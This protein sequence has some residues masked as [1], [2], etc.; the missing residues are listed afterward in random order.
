MK[1]NSYLLLIL[2]VFPV[3][4]F[5]QDRFKAG[6]KE[7]FNASKEKISAS[8]DAAGKEKLE[9]A[10]R[11]LAFSA[12]YDRDHQPALK[13]AN[14]DELVWKRLNGKNLEEAYALANQ[15]IKEDHQRKIDKLEQEMRGLAVKKQKSDALKAK[16]SVL[17]AKPLRIDS[18]NGQFVILCAFTN[19]SDQVLTAYETAIGYGSTEDLNDGWSCIKGPVEGT[20]FGAKE[21]KVLSCSFSFETV[22]QNSNVIKW[23]E[24]K[25]PL[26]DFSA[27]NLVMDCYTSMLVLNGVKYE[28]KN[29][30][31]LTE[32]EERELSKYNTALAQLNSST[33]V[34]EDLIV[35]KP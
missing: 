5:S 4:V 28:L 16:L 26:T 6:S 20:V 34:L 25:F 18:V 30:E 24:M 32:E 17:K 10:L 15:Y 23:K 13:K 33:P 22:K 14:F 29:E 21:T 2:I 7:K 1:W 8:L 31:R 3:L 11:V 19:E 27:C 35:K 9:L 12:I